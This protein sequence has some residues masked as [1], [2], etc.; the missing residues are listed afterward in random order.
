MM[1]WLLGVLLVGLVGVLLWRRKRRAS[2]ELGLAPF[3]PSDADHHNA[4]GM[5]AM[6]QPEQAITHFQ[7]ALRLRPDDPWFLTNLGIAQRR[8]GRLSEALQTLERALALAPGDAKAQH[9]LANVLA[10]RGHHHDAVDA[11]LKALA[12]EPL[13]EMAVAGLL[14]V[15]GS[16]A[17]EG[18]RAPGGAELLLSLQ[19]EFADGGSRLTQEFTRAV[20]AGYGHS[21][22]EKVGVLFPRWLIARMQE[23]SKLLRTD[24]SPQR[25]KNVMRMVSEAQTLSWLQEQ[26]R[27][28]ASG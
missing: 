9:S 8:S 25:L 2:S 17:T 15:L 5:Q 20:K 22:D 4:R 12:N 14:E 6:A 13:L 18:A 21:S 24:A 26:M 19:R 16:L 3:D 23:T 28:P 7:E 11:Y 1:P 10:E 27:S